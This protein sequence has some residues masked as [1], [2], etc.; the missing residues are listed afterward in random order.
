[1]NAIGVRGENAQH[2]RTN[3]GCYAG[4]QIQASARDTIRCITAQ[5]SAQRR[6]N[7]ASSACHPNDRVFAGMEIVS[8][9]GKQV[10]GGFGAGR[11]RKRANPV[12]HSFVLEACQVTRIASVNLPKVK[13]GF[14]W[15]GEGQRQ[16]G[17][18]HNASR[19]T[20]PEPV[21]GNPRHETLRPMNLMHRLQG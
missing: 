14:S 2:Q 17:A 20:E 21:Q 16:P 13:S 11:S 8:H 10:D 6:S 9:A 19:Q 12:R 4:G 7:S 18:K 15:F 1:M 5:K 3:T